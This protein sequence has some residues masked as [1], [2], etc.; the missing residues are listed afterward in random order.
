LADNEKLVLKLLL[1]KP[2]ITQNEL[3][4][5]LNLALKTIKRTMLSLKN[6]NIIERRGSNKKGYWIIK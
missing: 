3:T 4:K 1:K 6:K 2:S 5:E